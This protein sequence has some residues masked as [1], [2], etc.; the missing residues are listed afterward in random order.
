MDVGAFTVGL[1]AVVVGAVEL[2]IVGL[3]AEGVG[4]FGDGRGGVFCGAIGLG[5]AFSLALG[6]GLPCASATDANA[7]IV[8]SDKVVGFM[9]R[10]LC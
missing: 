9:V 6:D 3:G 5:A 4:G 7:S 8:M 1:G 10:R 2:D